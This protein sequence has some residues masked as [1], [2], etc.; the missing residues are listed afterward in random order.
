MARLFVKREPLYINVTLSD[1]EIKPRFPKTTAVEK[2]HHVVCLRR[3]L[4]FVSHFCAVID[5]ERTEL[6]RKMTV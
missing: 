5:V 6:R 3:Y 2:D 4:V 1:R